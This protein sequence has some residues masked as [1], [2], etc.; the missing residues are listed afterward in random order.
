MNAA[1]PSVNAGRRHSVYLPGE[2]AATQRRDGDGP[3]WQH[4]LGWLDGEMEQ[5]G[6]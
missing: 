6:I 5:G 1:M 4:G 2:D 3:R